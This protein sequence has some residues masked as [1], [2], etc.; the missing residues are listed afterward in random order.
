[1]KAGAVVPTY[2]FTRGS[3][4]RKMKTGMSQ[5]QFWLPGEL[6]AKTD[7][8]KL[9]S[10]IHVYI[11]THLYPHEYLYIYRQTINNFVL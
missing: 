1:M 6:Q 8:T 9:T 4:V 5:V 3:G 2:N 10:D 7:W 11:N